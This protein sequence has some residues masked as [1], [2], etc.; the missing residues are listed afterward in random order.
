M[1]ST[2]PQTSIFR[3]HI[4]WEP[5]P[6]TCSFLLTTKK[7]I[8]TNFRSGKDRK[9]TPPTTRSWYTANTV[10]CFLEIPIRPHPPHL[11]L[12]QSSQERP[13]PDVFPHWHD[14]PLSAA[15]FL[16]ISLSLSLSHIHIYTYIHEHLL[17]HSLSLSLSMG[18]QP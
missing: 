16:S 1:G 4:I 5:N 8:S 14:A 18:R 2:H 7:T 17:T 10:R 11:I 3:K 13:S 6:R 15:H 12:C 9:V